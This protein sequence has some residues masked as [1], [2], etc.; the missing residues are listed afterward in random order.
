M[1]I[2]YLFKQTGSTYI[3]DLLY[4]DSWKKVM[5]EIASKDELLEKFSLKD[6]QEALMYLKNEKINSNDPKEFIKRLLG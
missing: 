4:S 6:W 1:L 2:E 5:R 3:S